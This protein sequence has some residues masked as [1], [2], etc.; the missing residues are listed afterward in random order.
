MVLDTLPGVLQPPHDHTMHAI[1]G[2][3]EGCEDQRF[4]SRTTDGIAPATGRRLE[5]GDVMVLG[6]RA[7]HAI[8]SPQGRQARAIHVYFGN[9]YDVDR[10]IFDPESLEEFEMTEARYDEFCRADA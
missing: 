2:V 6:E 1:I 5:A 7:V 10:S 9:I 8:S 3:F 4:F